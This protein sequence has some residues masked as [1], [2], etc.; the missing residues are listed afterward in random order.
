M[1]VY[2][3]AREIGAFPA[4]A[5]GERPSDRFRLLQER[6]LSEIWNSAP[7]YKRPAW[8]SV[9]AR[10]AAP[11]PEAQGHVLRVKRPDKSIGCLSLSTRAEALRLID[12]LPP[13]AVY[14]INSLSDWRTK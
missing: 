5:S 1:K 3:K 12:R 8:L 10:K 11:R 2:L 9:P 6:D 4:L 14:S 13:G 7:F